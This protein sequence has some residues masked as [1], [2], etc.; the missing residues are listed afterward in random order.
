[1]IQK[2][3]YVWFQ[4]LDFVYKVETGHFFLFTYAVAYAMIILVDPK[5]EEKLIWADKKQAVVGPKL[6]N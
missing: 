3:L 5:H 4:N 6:E 2:L 1:M